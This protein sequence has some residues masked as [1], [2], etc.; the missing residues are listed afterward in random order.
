[1]DARWQ[2][3]WPR[4]ENKSRER[5]DSR[6]SSPHLR[7][8]HDRMTRQRHAFFLRCRAVA[9]AVAVARAASHGTQR[10]G[11][12]TLSKPTC[13]PAKVMALICRLPTCRVQ[14]S[15]YRLGDGGFSTR[16]SRK[17]GTND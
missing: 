14:A 15:T 17:N 9:T 7:F 4:H 10:G 8:F 16:G 11:Y 2:E 12:G 1:M 6:A 3:F 13:P 5:F